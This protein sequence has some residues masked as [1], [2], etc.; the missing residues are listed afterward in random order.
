MDLI[1]VFQRFPDHESCLEHLEQVRWGDRPACPLCGSVSVAR[2]ADS[3]RQGRWNCHDCKSSFN[4]LSG[5]I[6][7]KTKLPL[8]KWVSRYL[9]GAERQEEH[10]VSPTGPPTL[11]SIR[12][13]LGSWLCGYDGRWLV[14][15][16][17]YP[18]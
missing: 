5:T 17:C 2:K 16:S 12:S 9:A 11:T 10:I 1:K 18:A 6:F 15:A 4:V 3:F 13:L 8:Q 14:R 7:Q